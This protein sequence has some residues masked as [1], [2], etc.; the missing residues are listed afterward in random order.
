MR[1]SGL[2]R[3]RPPVSTRGEAMGHCADETFTC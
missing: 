1:Q 2:L 3:P